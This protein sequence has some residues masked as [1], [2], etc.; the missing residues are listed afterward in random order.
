MA[1]ANIPLH[2][3]CF[4]CSQLHNRLEQYG[5]PVMDL[6]LSCFQAFFGVFLHVCRVF[7]KYHAI[8][9]NYRMGTL[10][11]ILQQIFV[12]NVSHA[13]YII[14]RMGHTHMLHELV[15]NVT[16][17][18]CATRFYKKYRAINF[19]HIVSPVVG[20]S[21]TQLFLSMFLWI[22]CIMITFVICY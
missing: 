20:K 18:N 15:Q 17:Q 4:E 12:Q 13:C 6:F 11:N 9:K 10:V 3:H 2:R 8:L 7:H 16:R 22:F 21:I 19:L 1:L 5:A 14:Y